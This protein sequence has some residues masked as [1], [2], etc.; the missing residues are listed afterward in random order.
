VPTVQPTARSI[1][2]PTSTPAESHSPTPSPGA[3][4]GTDA[5]GAANAAD[6]VGAP[7]AHPVRPSAKPPSPSPTPT[8][9]PEQPGING[10]VLAGG[11]PVI[12]A[13]V[14]IS[15][16]GYHHNTTTSSQGR[17]QSAT[18]PGTYTIAA[19]S[20]SV[21]S[22]GERTVSVQPNAVSHVTITCETR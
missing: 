8:K 12:D 14:T 19:S 6:D 9:K 11:R 15:G 22:C 16:S 21:S 7:E 17:F 18:P 1:L 2:P 13:H 5:D 4:T 3:G 10:Q 20:P